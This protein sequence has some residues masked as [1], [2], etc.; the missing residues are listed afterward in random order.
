MGINIKHLKEYVIRPT[1]S[2]LDLWSKSAES[3]LIGTIAQESQA[4]YFLKQI[5]GPALGIYQI[6]PATHDDVWNNYLMFRE[7]L[8]AKVKKIANTT[9][10]EELIHNLAYGTAIARIIY[11]RAPQALPFHKN[12]GEMAQYWKKYYNTE[13]GKGTVSAFIYNYSKYECGEK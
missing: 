4:G 8:A 3:L 11:L 5:K 2:K 9:G 1:L 7:E 6:E 10:S 13:F 12:I